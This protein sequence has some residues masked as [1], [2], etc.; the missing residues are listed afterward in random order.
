MIDCNEVKASF[1][2]WAIG[3][4]QQIWTDHNRHVAHAIANHSRDPHMADTNHHKVAI[5]FTTHSFEEIF[6]CNHFSLAI[7]F[8]NDVLSIRHRS[9]LSSINEE[10]ERPTLSGTIVRPKDVRR[11]IPRFPVWDPLSNGG[12]V[13]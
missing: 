2:C 1:H 12:Y 4:H 3:R 7:A 5:N 9:G 10:A 8:D 6:L 13:V 11:R